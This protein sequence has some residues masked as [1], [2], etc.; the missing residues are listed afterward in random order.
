MTIINDSNKWLDLN[1]KAIYLMLT[2]DEMAQYGDKLKNINRYTRLTRNLFHFDVV[3]KGNNPYDKLPKELTRAISNCNVMVRVVNSIHGIFGYGFDYVDFSAEMPALIEQLGAFVD[4]VCQENITRL[5]ILSERPTSTAIYALRV[6]RESSIVKEVF[7]AALKGEHSEKAA[8]ELLQDQ[9]DMSTSRNLVWG[10]ID[11]GQASMIEKHRCECEP[12]AVRPDISITIKYVKTGKTYSNGKEQKRLGMELN[13]N[14]DIVPI[15]FGPLDQSV[16]YLATLRA[17]IEGRTI[18]RSDF[19]P[20][21]DNPSPGIIKCHKET[22][23]WFWDCFRIMDTERE[24]DK[25][26][27]HEGKNPHPFDVAV[28]GIKRKLWRLL[29]PQHK[30]AYYYLIVIN[31][32][33]RYKIRTNGQHISFDE[34]IAGRL[35]K[36]V[37]D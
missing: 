5:E 35:P 30:D 21:G 24:F 14:G 20:L 16:L 34:S 22:K 6:Y 1:N 10:V 33:G 9:S 12:P 15:P 8:V 28:G 36:R 26:Y 32:K 4:A 19:Y 18:R 27:E 2:Q 25:W 17:N 37:V 3:E 7:E 11:T 23:E 31:D 13:I 29:S